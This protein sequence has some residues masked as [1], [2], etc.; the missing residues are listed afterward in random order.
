MLIDTTK[1]PPEITD[2]AIEILQ[3]DAIGPSYGTGS[4]VLTVRHFTASRSCKPISAS[5]LKA[6]DCPVL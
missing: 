3:L 5:V 6:L 2:S 4:S 1:A